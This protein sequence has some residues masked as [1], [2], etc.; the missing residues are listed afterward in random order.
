[1]SARDRRKWDIL[2]V[3]A[4]SIY[5]MPAT[6]LLRQA[7]LKRTPYGMELLS[8]LVQDGWLKTEQS[9]LNNGLPVKLYSMTEAARQAWD[10]IE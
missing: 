8:E 10:Q 5:P 3:S 9:E 1:M 4:G 6:N 2:A 7:G